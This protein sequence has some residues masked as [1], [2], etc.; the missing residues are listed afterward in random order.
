MIN[1]WDHWLNPLQAVLDPNIIVVLS[2]LDTHDDYR[3]SLF[4][5]RPRMN[6]RRRMYICCA[7]SRM[8]AKANF[9]L[10]CFGTNYMILVKIRNS[11]HLVIIYDKNTAWA[12]NS[13]NDMAIYLRIKTKMSWVGE[14]ERYSL[15]FE[16]K[17]K[18]I[19][20]IHCESGLILVQS[21][22]ARF[23]YL[24]DVSL[25]VP[26][27]FTHNRNSLQVDSASVKRKFIATSVLSKLKGIVEAKFI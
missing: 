5:L 19:Q 27:Y 24:I 15:H 6:V 20:Y 4:N 14:W 23:I 22:H 1:H 21:T 2:C 26:L 3:D 7:R 18:M 10:V 25:Q 13:K 9:P 16:K 11:S 8:V 17:K 12:R